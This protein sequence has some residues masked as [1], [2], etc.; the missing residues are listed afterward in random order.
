[1]KIS[2]WIT[3]VTLSNGL[4][5]VGTVPVRTSVTIFIRRIQKEL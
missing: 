2:M 4:D 5:K 1:M 3:S